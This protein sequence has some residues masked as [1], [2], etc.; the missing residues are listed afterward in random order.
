MGVADR[1]YMQAPRPAGGFAHTTVGRLLIA[2]I[3]VFFVQMALGRSSTIVDRWFVLSGDA[4]A[5]WKI[6][7]LVTYALL[8]ADIQHLFWNGVGLWVF[9]TLLEGAMV[10]REF[11][12]F[13]VF[14]AIFSGLAFVM[15][16]GGAVIGVSGVVSAYVVGAALRFPR[17]GFQLLF[18]PF[19][20]PLWV[21]AAGYIVGDLTGAGRAGGGVAHFA[22]LG[23][24]LYAVVCWKFGVVP[25][26]KLPRR[27]A[28]GG[29]STPGYKPAEPLQRSDVESK[30]V[31]ALLEK[32]SRD[33]IASLSDDERTF[34]NEASRRYR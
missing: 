2:C 21:I 18:L 15:T 22:H 17:R 26:F 10:P 19:T 7:T 34:L 12:R 33:G 29:S 31:D 30:R 13:T 3:V 1:P 9:G 5:S 25:S 20:I 32:I 6:W 27:A 8:H 11:A 24:A 14:A 4:L 23:G 16:S 28:K